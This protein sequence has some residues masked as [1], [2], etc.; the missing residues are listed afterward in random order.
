MTP[1]Q[2]VAKWQRVSLSERSAC[3][4]HFLDLCDLFDHPKPVEADP[5]GTSFTF[6]R[7]VRKTDGGDGWADVWKRGHF[8]WEY[9]GKRKNLIAAYTQLLLYKDAL[10]N[11]PLLVVCDMDRFEVHTNFTDTAK[12]VHAFDLTGLAQ[13][14]NLDILR[15]VFHDPHALRPDVTRERI[16]QEAADRFGE[17]ADGMR[18]RGVP[19]ERA[20]HF[21]MKLM[22]CMFGEDIGLLPAGL[23][24][25]VVQG[26]QRN[27]AQFAKRLQ[28]LFAAMAEGGDFGAD[29]IL[30]FNGGLF[31]DA[32]VIPL[33]PE[34]VNILVAVNEYDWASVEPS[35]FGTLFERTLDP[36][37]R[38]Q[39]GAHYTSREDILTLLEPVLMAPLRCEWE[40]VKRC[41]E[42]LWANIE[43]A[44]RE[45]PKTAKP[46]A[47]K[48]SKSAKPRTLKESKH[49][50]AFD[51]ALLDFAERLAHVSVLD[52]ACGSGNFLYVAINLLLDLE[53]E[54]IAYGATRGVMLLPQ[55]RPTQL[56]GLEI[57]PYAHELA[58]VVIWIGYLQW[59]HHNG[60][61]VPVDP[62]LDPIETIRCTDAILDLSDPQHPKEPQWP[63]ADFIVGNPPF[64][65]GKLLRTNLGDEYV[66][67]VFSVW[68][69]RV[70]READLCCYWFEKARSVIEQGRSSRAGLLATQGIRGGA[71]R[72]VLQRIKQTGDIFFAESDRDWVLDGAAVHVSMVGFDGG[73]QQTRVLDGKPVKQVH[74]N[75]RATADTT[76][77]QPISG[78]LG[79][80]FMGDTKVGP[81]EIDEKQ[82][83]GFLRL[84]NPHGKANSD[85]VVPWVNGLDVTRR[86]RDI[87]IVDFPPGTPLDRA[88]LYEAP[89][90]YIEEHVRPVRK[91]AR[92]GDVTGVAWWIH[93]RP[94]PDMRA[95]LA[96]LSKFIA[97]TT[98][99]KHR[100][101]VWMECPT[102]PD[103]QLIVF[104]RSE[105]W[106]FGVLHSRIHELWA[107][108]QGT[109]LETRPRYTPTTC[110]ET[111]PLPEPSKKQEAAIAEAAR[112]LD[113]LRSAWL[114]PSEWTKEEVLEFPG[115]VDGPW[116][117]YVVEPDKRGIGTV[118][119]PRVVP[120]DPDCAESLK[121]R[122]LTNLYNERPAW[123]DL[124][125]QKLDAAVFAAY[126]WEPT[127]SDDALLE[128]LLALNL[129]RSQP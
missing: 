87:W 88:S 68:D 29:S 80:S 75:L 62:V 74:A 69:K 85:V 47:A 21:L 125:H 51:R 59:M 48:K 17:L 127:I 95:L 3:Q 20:A 76:I 25:R 119:W 96:R 112:E 23:F 37:K 83:I 117:R 128:R 71:N 1:Q 66:D 19:A 41:C 124:A 40:E 6:E 43:K 109:Q 126:G 22:F 36:G 57:N 94:R 38:S 15:K 27:P 56:A 110:F 2:F 123:L 11:P 7:G 24:T 55:V 42:G 129:Q 111:F 101:F 103:H 14:A 78:N 99:S 98:V 77:A 108:R 118:R 89:F 106:F 61:K 35:V 114:N 115:S 93:Q 113:Q 102:L 28:N 60:F 91:T 120:K 116:A 67:K 44:V 12:R 5:E 86:P 39:I 8:G 30:R 10:E 46:L 84:P 97:T 81:F 50:Q 63:A 52:P 49:R 33:T 65:G 100:L 107:L 64:L 73:S 58:Q 32:E 31:E 90:T 79:F 13:A 34:E 9:K 54:V 122:T 16:T 70:P 53:K 82:A 18:V 121:K 45:K 92:S 105:D 72:K 104:A 4:Q 26:A